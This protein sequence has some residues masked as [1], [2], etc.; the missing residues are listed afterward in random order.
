MPLRYANTTMCYR[1]EQTGEL[2][3]LSRTRAFAQ[4]D[5]HVFC[6]EAQIKEE[7]LKV[8]DIIDNFYKTFD[9]NLT[10][11]LSFHDPAQPENYLGTPETWKKAEDALRDIAKERGVEAREDIGEA[12][13]YGPKIDFKAVDS[14]GREWQVATIQ[15]DMNMPER[16]D[17]NCVSEEG[18]DERIFMIHAAIMGS[19]TRFMSVMIE[20]V[21]GAFPLWLAPVQ[22][23]VASVSE[24]HVAYCEELTQR[25]RDADIRTYLDDTNESVGK[26]IRNSAQ[27]K[28]PYTLVVGDKEANSDKLSI[29]VRGQEELLELTEKEFI[30]QVTRDTHNRTFK[31]S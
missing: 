16:F 3:G 2:H 9:F 13:F 22:V 14:I 8:W 10:P 15:L 17:L 30:A 20:H 19:I 4:D 12:A 31:L 11:T 6:R 21:A 25:F 24:N 18:K 26:K 23:A 5:A 7:F 27:Q 29:R 1:D 28:Y